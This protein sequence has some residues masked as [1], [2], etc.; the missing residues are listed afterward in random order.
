MATIV[1][2]PGPT[3][4]ADTNSS[5]GLIIGVILLLV[6]FFAFLYYGLP[7]LRGASSAIGRPSVSLPSQIDVNVNRGGSSGNAAPNT[8]SGGGGTNPQQ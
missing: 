4:T 5:L 8:N 3:G 6:M 7:A 1:N 2:N